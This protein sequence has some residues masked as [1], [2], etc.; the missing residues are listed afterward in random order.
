MSK[1][2]GRFI[3]IEGVEGVG[4]ST[5]IEIIE[6]ILDRHGIG[7]I[8]TREPG[9]T[10]LAEKIRSLLLDRDETGM[11]A[12]TELLLMF[13]ARVEHVETFIKPRL[14]AGE[15]VVCDRFTD[16]TYAYQGGGRGLDMTTIGEL[17]RLALG[18]FGPHY[19]LLLDLPVE[20]GRERAGG[21]GE[22]D[23]FEREGDGFF[24]R[25]RGVF[26][27]RANREGRFRIIDASLDL[28]GVREQ[29][30][31]AMASIIEAERAR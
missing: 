8:S 6:S 4:K 31:Q 28:D 30:E 27:D 10:P 16:S 29:I 2:P 22:P 19:T 26:L 14:A 15:W 13:A 9:G 17:E 21:R 5:S 1:I 12:M 11:D 3:T 20:I 24:Q 23:R 25:V 18:G 7:H